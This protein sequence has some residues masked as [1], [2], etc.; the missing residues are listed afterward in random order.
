MN[1]SCCGKDLSI[2]IRSADGT[3]KSCPRCSQTHGRMH[4]FR[5]YPEQFDTTPARITSN[6]PDGAQSHCISC[7]GEAAG[8]PS[9]V[10]FSRERMCD[11]VVIR[12]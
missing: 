11:T 7:R 2:S 3:L 1:C 4:V 12:D 5:K 9:H 8:A 10:D 6:N